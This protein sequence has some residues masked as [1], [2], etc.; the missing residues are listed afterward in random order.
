MA[1]GY[2]CPVCD[3]PKLSEPPRSEFGGGSFEICPSCGF[4]FGVNDDDE[5]ISYE[6][7]RRRWEAAGM[8]WTSVALKKLDS[9]HPVAKHV[10]PGGAALRRPGDEPAAPSPSPAAKPASQGAGSAANA[11][12]ANPPAEPKTTPPV[13]Q[14]Q[15]A[16]TARK[17]AATKSTKKKASSR[18]AAP[19]PK[20]AASKKASTRKP[21]AASKGSST[22]K[23]ARR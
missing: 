18:K 20:S 6:T 15:S 3:Y 12:T 7:W 23:S 21:S 2:I 11:V 16:A 9:W 5:G 19:P 22:R 4:Q 17:P 1:A 13:R 10:A 14:T 8:P